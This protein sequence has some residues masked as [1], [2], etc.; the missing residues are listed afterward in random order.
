VP[1]FRSRKASE[2]SRYQPSLNPI[3]ASSRGDLEANNGDVRN[4]NRYSRGSIGSKCSD[5]LVSIDRNSKLL[6]LHLLPG[7]SYSSWFNYISV[8]LLFHLLLA[9]ECSE[10][11]LSLNYVMWHTESDFER[12]TR[13]K[14]LT[15][16]RI[17][18]K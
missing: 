3:K 8:D 16:A 2:S 13:Q 9:S 11:S 12:G 18:I 4:Y 1:S 6:S 10:L 7:S 14:I 15:T 17:K 5:E